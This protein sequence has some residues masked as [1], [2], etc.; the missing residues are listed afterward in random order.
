[1]LP[2][3]DEKLKL[4][5]IKTNQG[6]CDNLLKRMTDLKWSRRHENIHRMNKRDDLFYVDK[7]NINIIILPENIQMTQAINA[8]INK[9]NL[10][11]EY[12]HWN[13]RGVLDG[14]IDDKQN[15][16]LLNGEY[17]VRKSICNEP[18]DIYKTHEQH[19][20]LNRQV[21]GYLTESIDQHIM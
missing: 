17:D 5:A 3:T 21:C 11:V 19:Y 7:E 9:T 20:C 6:G 14:F 13:N 12:L 16:Y 10:Y 8:Y 18:F 1:M 15:M 2:I 4:L